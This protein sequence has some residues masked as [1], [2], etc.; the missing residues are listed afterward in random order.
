LHSTLLISAEPR[1]FAPEELGESRRDRRLTASF[2]F[3]EMSS[4]KALRRIFLPLGGD[5]GSA[6]C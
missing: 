3:R 2:S 6:V 5:D 1:S 4:F